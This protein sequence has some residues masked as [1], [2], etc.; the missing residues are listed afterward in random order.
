MQFAAALP[1][2]WD[3]FTSGKV[4]LYVRVRDGRKEE[5]HSR[6]V[7]RE[8][9]VTIQEPTFVVGGSLRGAYLFT[10][11]TTTAQTSL[12]SFAAFDSVALGYPAGM[13]AETLIEHYRRQTDGQF[14]NDP[15]L[16]ATYTA[17]PFVVPA[18]RQKI[19]AMMN[20]DNFMIDM[21]TAAITGL[22]LFTSV[23]TDRIPSQAARDIGQPSATEYQQAVISSGE[24]PNPNGTN[25]QWKGFTNTLK[26]RL[27]VR[28]K[29]IA[30]A[31][32]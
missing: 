26:R 19:G 23:V 27:P 22:R 20:M 7:L 16:A 18:H 9:T 10:K 29:G 1:T 5:A 8:Q 14:T 4:R 11:L 24:V 32:E 21:K 28:P 17:V 6:L 12:A 3:G 13:E 2:G 15:F 31:A 30:K 25:K